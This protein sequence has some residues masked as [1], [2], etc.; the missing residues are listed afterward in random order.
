M[1]IS[2]KVL[3]DEV[4]TK[5]GLKK[6]DSEAAV[7]AV[8]EA[9]GEMLHRGDELAVSGFGVFKTYPVKERKVFSALAKKECVI[10]AHKC[11][12]FKA[13]KKFKEFIQ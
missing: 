4:A 6:K 1:Q 10:G 9:I 3:I 13:Y 5:T 7:K 12:S 11:V 2:K 8:F